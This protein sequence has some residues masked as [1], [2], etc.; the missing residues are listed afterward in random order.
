MQQAFDLCDLKEDCKEI[1][2]P[3]DNRTI[4]RKRL[5]SRVREMKVSYT[6][7]EYGIFSYLSMKDMRAFVK[8]GSTAT[9]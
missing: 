9:N 5:V 2:T 1:R 7:S 4:E 6:N 3:V 8:A